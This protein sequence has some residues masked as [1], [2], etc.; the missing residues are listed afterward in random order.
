MFTDELDTAAHAV[1]SLVADL[2][3]D[4]IPQCEL[5]ASWKV[6]DA[7]ERDAASAKTLLAR[8][9]EEGNTWRTAGYRSAAE[10]LAAIAGSSITAEKKAIET[11]RKVRKLPKTA[12]AMRNGKLS[13]AKA[14]AIA[15]AAKVA[16]EAEDKLLDGADTKPLGQLREECLKAKAID[17]DKAHK[18]IRRNRCARVYTT[19]RARGICTRGA[20]STPGRSSRPSGDR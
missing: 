10:Q 8:R 19:A 5:L 2:D 3:P 14:E 1:R 6:L 15:D 18:R 13:P 7:I 9:V 12:A 16:P 4:A 17:A 20:R 11:S